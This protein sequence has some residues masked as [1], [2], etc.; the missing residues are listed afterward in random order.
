M[1][2]DEVLPSTDVDGVV[3]EVEGGGG[4]DVSQEKDD[5]SSQQQVPMVASAM[6]TTSAMSTANVFETIINSRYACTKHQYQS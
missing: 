4:G 5:R 6:S 2:L 1:K 3:V